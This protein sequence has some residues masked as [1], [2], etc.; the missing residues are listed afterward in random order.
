VESL[1][2][3]VRQR[4][5]EC[6]ELERQAHVLR[7]DRTSREATVTRFRRD[8]HYWAAQQ[9]PTLAVG[10]I[11]LLLAVT[12][13]VAACGGMAAGPG[14]AV[15]LVFCGGCVTALA[16]VLW[17]YVWKERAAEKLLAIDEY[18]LAAEGRLSELDARI[19][20][21]QGRANEARRRW[22]S[23]YE[24]YSRRAGIRQPRPEA[25]EEYTRE[26]Y[27]AQSPMEA[28]LRERWWEMKG[29][30]FERFLRR[31]F[32][33]LGY[34]V[35]LTPKTGDQGIDL[36]LTAPGRRIGVQAKRWANNVG[37]E[38]VMAAYAGRAYYH[39]DSC[40]VITTSDFTRHAKELARGIG[41]RLLP[42][43]RIPDLIR[44][45]IDL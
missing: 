27:P 21:A 15:L 25:G 28:L 33:H 9:S 34:A 41:C 2:A 39:C 43:Q 24:V 40:I 10:G 6:E 19:A 35:E 18:L 11:L 42:G 44:G 14:L 16:T 45:N 8:R 37:N 17:L 22:E 3:T 20:A 31:V 38:A 29:T 23:A 30:E 1:A 32:R 12:V 36:I 4:A 5:S 26:P 13:L 7:Q